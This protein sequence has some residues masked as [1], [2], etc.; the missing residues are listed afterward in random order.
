[1]ATFAYASTGGPQPVPS[2]PGFY[3]N[4]TTLTLCKGMT[5]NIPI[6]VTNL[7]TGYLGQ[8]QNLQ[9]AIVDSKGIFSGTGNGGSVNPG[10][11]KTVNLPAFV[12]ANASPFINT[13][14]SVNFYF[15]NIYT[16]SEIRNI[17]FG[18]T[19]C[20]Q[21][22]SAALSQKVLT[23][24]E[25]ENV[26]LNLTNSGFT[27]LNSIS[28]SVIFPQSDVAWLGSTPIEI[29]SIPPKSRVSIPSRIYVYNGAGQAF[30]ANL[31]VDYYNGSRAMQVWDS[32]EILSVGI[33]N[34]TASS[35]TISPA[36]PQ[37]GGVFS[38]S[39]VLT[40]IGTASAS[41]V[42][43]TAVPPKGFMSF[44]SNSV[45][46]GD[47]AVDS[48]TPVTITFVSVNATNAGTY[49]M[50]I[51][52]SYLNSLRDNISQYITVPVTVLSATPHQQVSQVQGSGYGT[53]LF[54]LSIIIAV[55]AFL[56]YQD[57]RHWRKGRR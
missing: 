49:G 47:I 16:D 19:S 36:M 5:N 45:F 40:N 26:T 39:F 38:V 25:I 8:M 29:A 30:G 50:P 53:I 55:M 15:D 27:T 46:V 22:L 57:R 21:P 2:P 34:V 9:L 43:A 20:P 28:A 10:S 56:L 13:E 12:D 51:R 23:S 42:T 54:V 14:V 7:G 32:I 1:M 48:Q 17:T 3:I 18:T 33:I 4:T 41:A 44:G 37:A 24:G 31:S 35:F 6:T 52:I 11:S